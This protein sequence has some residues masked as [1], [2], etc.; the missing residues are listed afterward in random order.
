MIGRTAYQNPYELAK[1]DSVIYGKNVDKP[2]QSRQSIIL[3]YADYLDKVQN[4]EYFNDVG[5]QGNM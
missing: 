4:F 5:P 2:I 1:V 3:K